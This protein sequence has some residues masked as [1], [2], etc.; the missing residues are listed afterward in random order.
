MKKNAL[1][2][3]VTALSLSY[4][5]PVHAAKAILTQKW[6]TPNGVQVI[7]YPAREVPMLNINIAFAAGSAYDGNQYGLS[8]LTTRLLNDGNGGL[9]ADTLAE[10]IGNT[11]AQFQSD[12]NQDMV[13]L[14]L[15]TLT[16]TAPLQTATEALRLIIN[17]PDFPAAAFEREKEQQ[18]TAIKQSLESPDETANQTFFQA[19]Y[20]NHPYAHPVNG[21]QMTVNGITRDNVRQFYQKYFVGSNATIVLVGDID[22]PAA[23]HL[24]TLLTGDL[25]KGQPAS[26]IP[27]APALGEGKDIVVK[28]PASQ[29]MVRLGQIGIT[30][31]APDYFPLIVGNYILGGSG[32][33]SQL[34]TEIREKR[35]LTY[36]VYSQF[37][38]MPGNGPFVI[39][40]STKNADVNTAI[41]LSRKT[42]ARFIEQAPSAQEL[43]AA[44]DY[45]AGSFPLS[46][47]TNQSISN[48]LVKIAFYHLPDDFLDTYVR[49]INEVTADQ[50][51]QA[52]QKHIHTSQLL[53]VTVGPM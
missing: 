42:L 38:P 26:P 8:S 39:S 44:K 31:Q 14:S 19:L 53:Q 50:I 6:T 47:A 17:H 10:K 16:A 37:S 48:M 46:L 4:L 33:V 52:F 20:R 13:V 45:L 12:T 40:F 23:Q 36:G 29:T 51:H 7:F 9:T 11:G 32:L 27:P 22:L 15:R 1:V 2:A 5:F 3:L 41:D 34:A 25:P 35:G 18:L 43:T 21:N 49:R 28:F 24:V 30:H